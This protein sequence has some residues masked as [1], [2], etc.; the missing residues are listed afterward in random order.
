MS[1]RIRCHNCHAESFVSPRTQLY[2]ASCYCQLTAK[3]S[4]LVAEYRIMTQEVLRVWPVYR[5]FVDLPQAIL[6]LCQEVEELRQK[7]RE[8]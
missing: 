1:D 8:T 3:Y 6:S 7:T 2:C 5:T 4:E